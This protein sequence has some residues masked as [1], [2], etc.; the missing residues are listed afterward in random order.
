MHERA[1]LLRQST[2]Q[3]VTVN[4]TDSR[5]HPHGSWCLVSVLRVE[6]IFVRVTA[7]HLGQVAWWPL[8][9]PS[10]EGETPCA[11]ADRALFQW[12]RTQSYMLRRSGS[13]AYALCNRRARRVLR[14]VGSQ[15]RARTRHGA[16]A[17]AW[18]RRTSYETVGASC[19]SMVGVYQQNGR[20]QKPPPPPPRPLVRSL[21]LSRLSMRS[22]R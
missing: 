21:V 17:A 13:C 6:P 7:R 10:P 12:G 15:V 14:V 9:G 19:V 3:L 8:V 1:R 16:V 20:A 18:G 2:K 5:T 4:L 11:N 22:A